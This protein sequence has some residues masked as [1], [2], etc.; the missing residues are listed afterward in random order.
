MKLCHKEIIVEAIRV[1]DLKF[2]YTGLKEYDLWDKFT[3]VVSGFVDTRI[4]S[5]K[6]YPNQESHTQAALV[7]NLL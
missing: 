5:T 4:V 3:S 1:F 7:K 2:I 6:E